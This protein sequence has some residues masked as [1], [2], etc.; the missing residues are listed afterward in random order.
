M[1]YV[2]TH[3]RSGQIFDNAF[4]AL[5]A[6]GEFS[7]SGKALENWR[8]LYKFGQC[9]YNVASINP[10]GTQNATR[11]VSV[12]VPTIDFANDDLSILDRDKFIQC[13]KER[14][15]ARKFT[16][17]T[18]TKEARKKGVT[19]EYY[20][21]NGFDSSE[22]SKIISMIVCQHRLSG[23][24]TYSLEGKQKRKSPAVE[25][26]YDE[27][28]KKHAQWEG[29][30][31]AV[32]SP[33]FLPRATTP[34]AESPS[35]FL[36][37]MKS[38]R[39]VATAPH[40]GGDDEPVGQSAPPKKLKAADNKLE[41]LGF[42]PLT[43]GD[44][45]ESTCGFDTDLVAYAKAKYGNTPGG[46]SREAVKNWYKKDMANRLPSR[47]KGKKFGTEPG[48]LQVLHII[49]EAK[50]GSDWVFNYFIDT[51][52]VNRYFGKSLPKEWDAYVG[53]RATV[54]AE[55]FARW[56]AKKAKAVL[57]FAP[58]DPVLD[59]YLAR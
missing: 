27:K 11:P 29:T 49:S 35:I 53:K 5:C 22:L 38:D 15:P 47:H 8:N 21:D 7:P 9:T 46:M 6:R 56:V 24:V 19:V 50:G 25:S 54:M 33:F 14:F 31:Q 42:K 16:K 55:T 39:V 32:I 41:L 1:E 36:N 26:A 20:T 57:T 45:I 12:L 2:C 18:A 17:S 43:I 3:K 30:T 4:D 23:R 58:F 51:A 44:Q 37:S 34:R 10:D 59:H 13:I 28:K 48:D 52:E 40:N